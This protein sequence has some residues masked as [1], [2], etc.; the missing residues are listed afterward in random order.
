MRLDLYLSALRKHLAGPDWRCTHVRPLPDGSLLLYVTDA[1]R[2]NIPLVWGLGE[3]WGTEVRVR[4]A[5]G[6]SCGDLPPRVQA[7]LDRFLAKARHPLLAWRGRDLKEVALG[8]DGEMPRIWAEHLTV[9]ESGW[10]PFT[11]HSIELQAG[12]LYLAFESDTQL[13]RLRASALGDPRIRPA[14]PTQE[15]GKLALSIVQDTRP[16]EDRRRG[17]HQPELYVAF[18]LAHNTGPDTRIVPKQ[19]V[20][21][22]VALWNKLSAV[23]QYMAEGKQG[24]SSLHTALSGAKRDF[25]VVYHGDASCRMTFPQVRQV[26]SF[27]KWLYFPLRSEHSP[28]RSVGH[29][30]TDGDVV[31]GA[32]GRLRQTLETIRDEHPGK[33]TVVVETCVSRLIGEDVRGVIK[34]VYGANARRVP[35]I[36]PDFQAR[37]VAADSLVWA[38]LFESLPDKS[39]QA[40]PRT[41]NLMGFGH[42]TDPGAAELCALLE[43]EGV[44]VQACLFPSF[45]PDELKG[46]H[47][48]TVTIVSPCSQ[49]RA[50]VRVASHKLAS[51]RWLVLDA[52]FG[53]R[54]TRTWLERVLQEVAIERG[55]ER[56]A[57]AAHRFEAEVAVRR[58]KLGAAPFAF[59]SESRYSSYLFTPSE[60]FGIPLLEVLSEAGCPVQ[61]HVLATEPLPLDLA[62]AV[63][64][65]PQVRIFEHREAEVLMTALRRGGTRFLFTSLERN[66]TA[67]ELGMVPVYGSTFEMGFR[68]AL[69]TIDKLARL[70]AVPFLDKFK[71]YLVGDTQGARPAE[72][73]A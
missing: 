63:R 27:N 66:E 10:G 3:P 6:G 38:W 37:D 45:D 23:N 55:A 51:M 29:D 72:K 28:G 43:A 15:I 47:R 2:E 21:P 57:Q 48:A 19:R 56:A 31:K 14:E 59:S 39:V 8:R 41:V 69:R 20:I 4:C 40:E 46:L 50:A 68:G 61:V 16:E 60:V 26:P 65:Y 34:D 5:S 22:N 12:A 18:I 36:E 70:A 71:D 7:S 35:V 1:V 62:V 11:L 49:V 58:A 25:F 30:F 64:R 9:S 13:V 17:S 54:G 32:E 52:P 73:M 53:I 24:A 42:R 44:R 67:V 33:P